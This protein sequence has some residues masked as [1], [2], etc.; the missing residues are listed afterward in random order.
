MD[1]DFIAEIRS[2]GGSRIRTYALGDPMSARTSPEKGDA[3]NRSA[4]PPHN[5]SASVPRLPKNKG[6]VD[7]AGFEP[8][9]FR[10]ST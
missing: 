3:F 1:P 4:I 6:L 5:L 9:A 10:L 7:V 8:A 2:G